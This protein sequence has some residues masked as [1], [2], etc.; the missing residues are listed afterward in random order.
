MLNRR[1]RKCWIAVA[2]LGAAGWLNP[3]A[4]EPYSAHSDDPLNIHDAPVRSSRRGKRGWAS[5]VVAYVPAPG[6]IG[7]DDPL[8]ALGP[9][10]GAT[11]SLG[12]LFEIGVNM[13]PDDGSKLPFDER[14]PWDGDVNDPA[15][16]Y[17]FLGIDAI[18]SITVGFD[19]PIVNR[20]GHDLA[21]FEN[22]FGNS[23]STDPNTVDYVYAE[24][25]FVE[26]STDGV[27]FA[28]FPSVF[29]NALGDLDTE[30]GRYF[31]AMDPTHIYNLAGK[32]IANW[33]TPF[34]LDDL[35]ADPL[36]TGGDVDLDNIQF[37]RMI[38]IVGNGGQLDASS[39]PIFDSWVGVNTGG[40]DLDAVAI[41]PEPGTGGVAVLGVLA[42]LRRRE[43]R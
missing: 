38:D 24:L 39:R 40:F 2:A 35:V 1:V 26:V 14:D 22:G 29:T 33:G 31:A 4:A 11:A 42:T 37:V 27:S 20:K 15:D 12:D 28:R 41:L 23:F 34:D 21:I 6:V 13:P 8:M 3:V 7:N 10:D 32:H 43:R 30:F 36:V 9:A 5:H 25:A 16:Q 18:G 19:E 17:G